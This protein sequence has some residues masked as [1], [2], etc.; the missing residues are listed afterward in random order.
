M[1]W[2][3]DRNMP[4]SEVDHPLTRSMPRLKALERAIA[5]IILPVYGVMYD[6]VY[7][8][9]EVHYVLLSMSPLDGADQTIASHV[10]FIRNI[11]AIYGQYHQST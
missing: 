5:A 1:E 4:L 10:A 11:L 7:C 2:V 6:E 9:L 3:V 8:V